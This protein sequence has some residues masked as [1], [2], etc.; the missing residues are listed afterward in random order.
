MLLG[1]EKKEKRIC[2]LSRV[3]TS[4]FHMR[5]PHCVAFF[6]YLPWFVDIYG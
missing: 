5:F 2:A 6:N 4:G 1:V 3:A